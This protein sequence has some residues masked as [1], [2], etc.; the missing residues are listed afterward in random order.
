MGT[1][2]IWNDSSS[3][4]SSACCRYCCTCLLG[5]RREKDSSS[6][7][8]CKRNDRAFADDSGDG[9]PAREGPCRRRESYGTRVTVQGRS[10]AGERRGVDG[11]GFVGR[12]P[13]GRRTPHSDSFFTLFFIDRRRE[14]ASREGSRAR[15]RGSPRPK[16]SRS[17]RRHHRASLC[18]L[19]LFPTS[20]SSQRWLSPAPPTMWMHP[21]P[22]SVLRTRRVWAACHHHPWARPRWDGHGGWQQHDTRACGRGAAVWSVRVAGNARGKPRQPQRLAPAANV[23]CRGEAGQPQNA[24]S[25]SLLTAPS[26]GPPR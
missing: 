11:V 2:N 3:S 25:P 21:P 22:M 9:K 1:G 4:S 17:S 23:E 6:S 10:V 26:C 18:P 8:A 13:S 20:Y 14:S 7:S 5:S 12:R 15:S 24:M 16:K 19:L